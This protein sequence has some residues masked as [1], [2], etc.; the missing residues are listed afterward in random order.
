MFVSLPK[1]EKQTQSITGKGLK[2]L[3][4]DLSNREAALS[5]AS[6]FDK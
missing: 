4:H 2:P 6:L 5:A 1:A 3:V